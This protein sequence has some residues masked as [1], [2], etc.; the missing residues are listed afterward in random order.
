MAC[1]MELNDRN[2]YQV[3]ISANVCVITVL[4]LANLVTF[5]NLLQLSPTWSSQVKE[6]IIVYDRYELKSLRTMVNHNPGFC[7]LNLS[8]VVRVRKLKL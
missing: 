6:N 1:Q 5:W 8:T 4:I 2:N 7:K 3:V